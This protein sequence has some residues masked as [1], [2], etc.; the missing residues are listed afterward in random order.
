MLRC[1]VLL[2]FLGVGLEV[3][4]L[5]QG[6]C[7]HLLLCLGSGHLGVF[8]L[9]ACQLLRLELQLL[10]LERE[11][12]DARGLLLA[13]HAHR[14]GHDGEVVGDDRDLAAR[15]LAETGDDTVGGRGQVTFVLQGGRFLD[16]NDPNQL[17]AFRRAMEE[18]SGRD[19]VIRGA[20]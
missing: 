5:T 13:R 15:D 14:T 12:A 3:L 4:L 20:N 10:L 1:H 11:L 6:I 8:A 17:E 7:L 18:F 16:M 19:V 2:L 9:T